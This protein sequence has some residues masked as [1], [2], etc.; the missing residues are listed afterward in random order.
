MPAPVR[1]RLSKDARRAELLKAGER[2][3]SDR[4][5]D[6]VSIDDIAAA[7]GISKNLLYH[8][9]AGKRELYLA[10]ISDA[11]EGMLDA[12]EPDPALEPLARLRGSLECHLAY[13]AEHASGYMA[14]LR[15]AGGDPDVQVIVGRA[16]DHVVER[17]LRDLPLPGEAPPE[18]QLA[19]RGWI[20]LVDAL[21]MD[22]LD[23][24]ALPRERVVDLL[25]ELF[26]AIVTAA[27]TVA[28]R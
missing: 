21:T 12:T 13:A 2:V 25:A 5:F 14:L 1:R 16:H 28:S 11:A 20:G 27:A 24:Q 9:F 17:I 22:W 19:L 10:V 18:V 6:D 7:A 8:Y 23:G 4:P 3:F 26:V 15:G